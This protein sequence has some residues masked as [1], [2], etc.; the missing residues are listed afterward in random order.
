MANSEHLS[1]LN[2]G[3]LVWNKWRTDHPE[4]RPDMSGSDL[5]GM[6]LRGANLRQADFYKANLRGTDFRDADLSEAFLS[7]VQ[8][9]DAKISR[10]K[11]YKATLVESSLKGTDLSGAYVYGAS[12]WNVELDSK[13]QQ[14]GLII[15]LPK[16][17]TVTVDDLEVAQFIY[18]LLKRAKLRNVIETLT[19]KAV[20]ILGRFTPPRKMI[21]EAMATELRRH[22]LLPII[23]DFERATSRDFTETI[24][25]LAGLSLFVIADITNP[26]SAPLE[27][28]AL[29]PDYQI[30]FVPII[31]QGEQ[32]FSML[33][34]LIGKYDWVLEPV[35]RYA[36]V[37]K[38]L[39]NFKSAIIDRAWEKH[40]ELQARK[41]IE[42]KV[43]SIEEI[44]IDL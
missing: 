29:V 37:E 35:I 19:S 13:S 31:Q 26:K 2:E 25:T 43:K 4:I 28:Q 3:V 32:P 5:R 38:L 24:K 9:D 15:T 6:D 21:L 10:A 27:L 39:Q 42:V 14:V 1:I 36:T 8:L 20:L 7:H 44:T 30:P 11:L 18:L 34:D 40:K 23:F 12:V 16:E 41:A 33:R 22:K 17:A